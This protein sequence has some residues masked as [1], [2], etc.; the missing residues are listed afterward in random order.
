MERS[1]E[2]QQADRKILNLDTCVANPAEIRARLE[3]SPIRRL[4]GITIVKDGKVTQFY[5]WD[6][7]VDSNGD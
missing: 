4:R 1:G 6:A 2:D 5:P 3:R 7:E